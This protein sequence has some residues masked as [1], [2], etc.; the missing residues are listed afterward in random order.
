MAQAARDWAKSKM[1]ER[2]ARPATL[3]AGGAAPAP[4]Q[5]AAAVAPLPAGW[6]EAKAPDGRTYY[7][8][9]ETK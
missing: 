1:R 4:G 3:L 8:H 2:E 6:K 7:F 5:M 9:T